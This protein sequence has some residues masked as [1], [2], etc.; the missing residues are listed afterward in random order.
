MIVYIKERLTPYTKSQDT[1]KKAKSN[2]FM[3]SEQGSYLKKSMD[4]GRWITGFESIEGKTFKQLE[5]DKN[6]IELKRT[7]EGIEN[8][9]GVSLDSLPDNQFLKSFRI[10]L[11]RRG[12]S[13]IKLNM[14]LPKDRFT[15]YAAIANGLVAPNEGSLNEFKYLNTNYFFF[16]P[17][18]E[19]VKKKEISKL[20]N[21]ISA[22]VT[23]NEENRPW[24]LSVTYALNLP[25][26]PELSNNH[27]YEYIDTAKDELNNVKEAEK[28]L[29]IVDTDPL[30]L[31][32]NFVVS[33]AIY[34][35]IISIGEGN[36][37]YFDS[38]YL[39]D[40]EQDVKEKLLEPSM[41][42]M[43]ASLMEKVFKRYKIQY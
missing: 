41:E 34:S 27:L 37:K 22:K 9:L 29:S 19:G 16:S 8:A 11:S 28:F 31:S 12:S 23:N 35:N 6:L 18:Q 36:K 26:S 32:M 15:Y 42:G 39:G 17:K 2:T 40:T 20:K 13:S 43:Y 7:K 38:V 24:L 4:T 1:E 5:G 14:A 30:T 33:R 10:L 25:V 21:K 3:Y